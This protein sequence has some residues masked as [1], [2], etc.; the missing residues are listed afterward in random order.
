MRVLFYEFGTPKL[1]KKGCARANLKASPYAKA[2]SL[3]PSFYLIIWSSYLQERR[4]VQ[5][6]KVIAGMDLIID[7]K[8]NLRFAK[9]FDQSE[10]PNIFA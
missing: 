10:I 1:K 9:N 3:T 7:V 4:K 2:Q 5:P 6:P 8:L